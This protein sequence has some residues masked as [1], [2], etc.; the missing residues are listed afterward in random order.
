MRPT[1]AGTVASSFTVRGH[2]EDEMPARKTKG[3]T[4]VDTE[5][6]VRAEE[7]AAADGA[8]AAATIETA[9]GAADVTRGEDEVAAAAAFSA[10]PA[11][12]IT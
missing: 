10:V 12:Q 5:R 1:Y 7:L 9:A 11:V 4:A 8:A 6:K 3:K 2:L